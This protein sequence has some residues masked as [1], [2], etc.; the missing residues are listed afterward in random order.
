MTLLQGPANPKLLHLISTPIA[1][2]AKQGLRTY[3]GVTGDDPSNAR[4]MD[5]RYLVL[6][7]IFGQG[8]LL[9]RIMAGTVSTHEHYFVDVDAEVAKQGWS[10][11][12]SLCAVH[13]IPTKYVSSDRLNDTPVTETHENFSMYRTVVQYAVEGCGMG[14]V[15][16]ET[17]PNFNMAGKKP[18][19]LSF[20]N[21][22]YLH[23]DTDSHLA[24]LNYS[25]SPD[26]A[27]SADVNIEF[28]D[29][30]G[31]S[32]GRHSLTVPAMDFSSIRVGDILSATHSPFVSFTAASITSALIPISVVVHRRYGG[33]SVEH[34]HP[35]Q[36]YLMA[37]WPV[38]N[39]VKLR[40]AKT[41][42]GSESC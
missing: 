21:K 17:P 7:S 34:S 23:Q 3:A 8:R 10:E 33:V 30:S 29:A 1:I 16:Y 2:M 27:Q 18:H 14:S 36:E 24:F 35:P 11:I 39:G 20:S 12:A 38:I 25:V 37:D 42:F 4:N 22:I 40:A 5:E 9:G 26:Y 41:L 32:R 19:F 13:R 15:I 6:L 28:R 31:A